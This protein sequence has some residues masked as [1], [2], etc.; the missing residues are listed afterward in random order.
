[1]GDLGCL[2]RK[3]IGFL[4]ESGGLWGALGAAEHQ[5]LDFHR[6]TTVSIGQGLVPPG[7]AGITPSI[8]NPSGIKED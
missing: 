1:M 2:S 8:C 5:G 4:G 6:I 7:S 3:G